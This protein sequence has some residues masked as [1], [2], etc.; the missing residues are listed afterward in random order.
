MDILEELFGVEY[1]EL[2]LGSSAYLFHNEWNEEVRRDIHF[3]LYD[4]RRTK[5]TF[6]KATIGGLTTAVYAY[7]LAGGM[8]SEPAFIIVGNDK[9]DGTYV[10]THLFQY[11]EPEANSAVGD[12]R[13]ISNMDELETFVRKFCRDTALADSTCLDADLADLLENMM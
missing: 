10:M 2:T 1:A 5:H 11:T 8:F 13:N 9:S 3:A 7:T 4:I 6:G 12:W